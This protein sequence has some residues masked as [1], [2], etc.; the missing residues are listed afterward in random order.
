MPKWV[1]AMKLIR[2]VLPPIIEFGSRFQGVARAD[3]AAIDDIARRGSRE[4]A[5]NGHGGRAAIE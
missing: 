5:L 2:A 3:R 1:G 4:S